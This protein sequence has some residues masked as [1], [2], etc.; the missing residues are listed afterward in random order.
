ML[1]AG[2]WQYPGVGLPIGGFRPP[3]AQNAGRHPIRG[4]PVTR[5][6]CRRFNNLGHP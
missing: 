3:H 4:N 2:V 5:Y 6:G 1:R